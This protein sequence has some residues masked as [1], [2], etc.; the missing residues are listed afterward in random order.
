MQDKY[1]KKFSQAVEDAEKLITL[2]AGGEISG[3]PEEQLTEIVSYRPRRQMVRTC[4]YRMMSYY[5]HI[6]T[7]YY[8]TTLKLEYFHRIL[9]LICFS[10]I[11]L[12]ILLAL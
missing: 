8:S 7:S 3:N 1:S 6:A 5:S 11:S 10:Y 12:I 9:A 4:T 2:R